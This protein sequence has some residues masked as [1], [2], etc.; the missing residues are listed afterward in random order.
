MCYK[1]YPSEWRNYTGEM[2]QNG[3]MVETIKAI[4]NR[5]NT[6][7]I[8]TKSE[9]I[10]ELLWAIDVQPCLHTLLEDLFT[11]AQSLIDDHCVE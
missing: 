11:D 10:S 5:C 6:I 9:N 3:D 8:L 1:C 7:L 4:R 2:P